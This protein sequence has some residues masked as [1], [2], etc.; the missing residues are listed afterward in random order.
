MSGDTEI[1]ICEPLLKISE[2]RADLVMDTNQDDI[3]QASD[4]AVDKITEHVARCGDINE[5][6]IFLFTS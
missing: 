2:N 1:A 5:K 4:K 3:N 6:V